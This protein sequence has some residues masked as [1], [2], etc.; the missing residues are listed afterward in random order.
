MMVLKWL[1]P[2]V[3]GL[4]LIRTEVS[5]EEV[6]LTLMSTAARPRC[7]ACSRPARRVHSRYSRHVADAPCLARAVVHQIEVRRFRCDNQRCPRRIFAERLGPSIR[8]HAR[9]TGRQRE[10]LEAVGVAM[11]AESAARLS[12]RLSMQVSAST[13]L[14]LVRAMELP[15]TERPTCI[16]VDD[17]AFRR[18][19]HYGT[20][21]VDLER[22]RPIDLLPDREGTT[23]VA[24]LKEH[25]QIELVT[26]D[27]SRIYADAVARGAPQAIQVADRWH[28]IANLGD[29]VENA[30]ARHAGD[31]R[32]A[33]R[34]PAL[35][36]K[37]VEHNSPVEPPPT[38][39]PADTA[40]QAARRQQFEEVLRLHGE[41]CSLAQ[42]G[43]E[44]HLCRT[45]VRRYILRRVLPHCGG[46]AQRS[47]VASFEGYVRQRWTEGCQNGQQL[48][49]EIR[50]QGFTGSYESIRRLLRHLRQGDGRS[51]RY[52]P[53]L[54]PPPPK[55][56][57]P[58]KAKWLFTKAADR[59]TAEDAGYLER[60]RAQ[61]A[62]LDRLYLLCQRF[63]DLVRDGDPDEL[64]TWLQATHKESPVE[65][66]RFAYGIERDRSA[67]EAALV[68]NWSNGQLEGQ[69]NRLKVIK[70]VMYG[71]ANFDLLRRR[72]LLVA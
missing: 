38:P 41:G 67:V 48:W 8:A 44:V 10:Q 47:T 50:D 1:L 18:G 63:I 70:R 39:S 64:G 54:P 66:K 28:L 15:V 24:W 58:R 71:R 40:R 46:G 42:I 21:I 55:P 31:L 3:P 69:V 20:L 53:P 56:L 52:K 12:A 17:W 35:G 62:E 9:R 45:T 36:R 16:G 26:R 49:R 34:H 25:P 65:L 57:S 30:L 60:L 19:R 4:K 59:L 23:L 5:A 6:R 33:A 37:G 72:V 51:L 2:E 11:S 27:R 7:P 43:R 13:V 14:R 68:M 22:R 61:S 32:E 29:A